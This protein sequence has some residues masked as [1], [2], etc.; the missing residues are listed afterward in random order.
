MASRTYAAAVYFRQL[1]YIPS[2]WNWIAT[3]REAM[4]PPASDSAALRTS[5][6]SG[7]SDSEFALGDGRSNR[8][9]PVSPPPT[10]P[11]FG[12]VTKA[13]RKPPPPVRS[14]SPLDPPKPMRS[15]YPSD[16]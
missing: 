3:K 12:S 8:P 2:G 13:P 5:D 4:L 14:E 15:A 16:S 10:S 7:Q 6:T 11:G 9:T 1:K